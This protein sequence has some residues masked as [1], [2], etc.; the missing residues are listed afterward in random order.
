MKRNV[1][2]GILFFVMIMTAFGGQTDNAT[3]RFGI[4][5]G[6]NNGGRDRV[7]L[8]YAVS[9]AR[10]IANVF[11]QMGGIASEDSVFLVEPN[12]R[13]INR[14]IDAMHEQ[15]LNTFKNNKRTEIVFYYSGH[16]DDEGLLLNREKYYYLEL[17]EKINS[18]PSDMRIVILDSCASG[19]FTRIKG[20]E[21]TLPFLLD[22]S[23]TAEGYAFLTSSSANES[24]QESDRI[25]SSYFTHSLVA[26]LRGAADTAGDGRVTLNELYRYAYA[27][28]MARTETS[29][30]GTQH[31]SYDIQIN[32][33]GDLVLTDVKQTSAG[34]VIDEKVAGRLTIRDNQDRLVMEIN[35]IA[36]VLELGL[37]PGLY[38]ITLQ[39]GGDLFR[40]EVTL[41]QGQRTLVSMK[42]FNRIGT[43]P[44]RRRGDDEKDGTA[45]TNLY[46]L[47]FNIV[48][49]PFPLPLIGFVNVAIGNHKI[50]QASFVNLNTENFNG[51]Q[52]GFV[53]TVGG[54]FNGFQAGFI[55]T[56][57]GNLNGFQ[58]G[59]VN[60][61]KS[62]TKGIQTGFVNTS[63]KMEGVQIGFVNV[64]SRDM[65][66]L[67]VGF[68][69]YTESING[70]PIG[71]ISV[72]KNGGYMA[73]EYFN[74]E[75]HNYNLSFKTGIDKL[76]TSIV[77]SYNQTYENTWNNFTSGIGIG[78]ILP[79]G[80]I[81][82]F[83]PELTSLSPF[84]SSVSYESF[85]PYF[86]VNFKN[87]SIAA[88][89]VITWV[90]RNNK[91]VDE[92][93][94]YPAWVGKYVENYNDNKNNP[95]PKPNYSLYYHEINDNNSISIGFRAAAR[96]RF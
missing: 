25:A 91:N 38:N 66:G 71:F 84:I 15:V 42:D 18:I 60:V 88:G 79:I 63:R 82:Y 8:R 90:R 50:F 27:E 1:I 11:L 16:S 92:S 56:V 93:D 30:Y 5:I 62:E 72:V 75:Y 35:K 81:F 12:I 64:A 61:N 17:R 26:G 85:V 73:V 39:Q 57:G 23:S 83:N 43:D 69:N 4:F 78:S 76:Y 70:A 68:V 54:N 96:L 41:I 37:E 86:G 87:F 67:Q 94:Q 58:A 55:N 89:P 36:R 24:S 9:D 31:P 77:V 2:F 34:I 45:G 7:M 80:K 51:F 3:R 52:A 53:D 13:E 33:S 44:T 59:F 48:Y 22:N 10:S 40:A 49:E 65:K 74:S 32:G 6:S 21:K 46:T 19:A 47:F 14:R 95:L 20:G 28:T 29:L